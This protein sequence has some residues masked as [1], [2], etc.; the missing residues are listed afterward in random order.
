MIG[1]IVYILSCFAAAV[2]LTFLYVMMRPVRSR[3]ELKSWRVLLIMY[4]VCL[5]G[6]YA[7]AEVMTKLVGGPMANAVNTAIDE[8]EVGGD[9]QY[10]KVLTY[11]GHSARVIAVTHGKA[12]WGGT[13][14]PVIAMT[15]QKSGDKW[16]L[17]SYR[18]VSSWHT[19]DD[20]FTF[21]PYY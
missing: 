6:P 9:L 8:S 14:K 16:K 17:D 19:G 5:G 2:T 1:I 18:I 3:D 13:D 12:E 15:L 10:Y 4:I 11:N 7:Y 21:P 20:A